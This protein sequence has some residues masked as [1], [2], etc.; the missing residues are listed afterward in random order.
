MDN[1]QR[2][3]SEQLQ[4]LHELQYSDLDMPYQG[5][6]TLSNR[7]SRDSNTNRDVRLLDTIALALTTG[8]PGDVIA[9]AF[10]KREQMQLVLAKNGPPTPDDVAA[11]NEFISLIGSPAVSDAMDLF[12]FL[13][14]RCGANINKRI[15]NLHTSIRDEEIRNDFALAL[16]AY[17]PEAG[18]TEFPGA[19]W[20]LGEYGDAAP[21]IATVWGDFVEKITDRTAQ[22]LNAGDVSFS[23]AKYAQIFL[24]ANA[25]KHSR[26]LKTII[27]DRTDLLPND[28]KWRAEKLKR[29]LDKVCQYVSGISHLIKKA[30]RYFP[31]PHHWV[32][33]TFTGTGESV[34]DL[35]D[36]AY[37]AVSRGLD[38]P[39]LSPE[40]VDQ[41]GKHFPSIRSNWER[42]QTM[43]TCIHAELRVI[44]HLGPPSAIK[45]P[46]H[47]IGVSKRSC[48]CCT[49]WIES[50][51][52]IFGTRWMTS[53]SHGK[54]YANWALPGAACSYAIQAD[55]RSSVDKAVLKPVSTRLTDAL[56]WLFP[57][58][59]RIS[60][61][62]VLNGDESSDSE[63]GELEWRLMD[64]A[65][66][67]VEQYHATTRG[68]FCRR[69]I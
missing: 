40:I 47:P 31:I 2:N 44:L 34:F 48:F 9:A 64:L 36:N 20:L 27:E 55:G 14:R 22:G 62:Y 57:G 16:K 46:V 58:Q 1:D 50:H 59:K 8:N 18:I 30:K 28:R 43:H 11:A 38:R 45:P 52:R 5:V 68:N 6:G 17:E 42:Q 65:A 69:S 39:S 19:G 32:M 26:F 51:N 61:E 41:L 49:L 63:Q 60:D 7:Q 21:P 25:L 54:P 33:D 15:R 67:L 37:D 53:G 10:D 35:C 66:D 13:L 4:L 29:R 56:D 24:H 23:T 12:P 3:L